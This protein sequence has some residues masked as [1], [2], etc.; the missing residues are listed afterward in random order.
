[1]A[2]WPKKILQKLNTSLKC[3]HVTWQ[4][5]WISIKENIN[6]LCA[7]P[8]H[9]HYYRL[10]LACGMTFHV[11]HSAP[12]TS[13]FTMRVPCSI[14]WG[15]GSPESAYCCSPMVCR[16]K[17]LHIEPL[18]FLS[19]GYLS[20]ASSCSIEVLSYWLIFPLKLCI[21]LLVLWCGRWD[22][23]HGNNTVTEARFFFFFF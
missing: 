7:H 8:G 14:K 18:T 11:V 9:S 10:R 22:A 16:G 13:S 6:F 12:I 2:L 3:R 19:P 23:F 5:E 20:I 21:A 1:M 15:V 4:Q 17:R